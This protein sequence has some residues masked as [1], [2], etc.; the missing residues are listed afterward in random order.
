MKFVSARLINFRNISQAE[1]AFGDQVFLVGPNAQGKT[2]ILEA[3]HYLSLGGSFRSSPEQWLIK[4]GE[5]F[6]RIEGAVELDGGERREVSLVLEQGELGTK[7]TFQIDQN[8]VSRRGFLGNVLTVL[9]A[10]DAIG[11]IRLQ[12]AVRRS[13]INAMMA[14]TSPT[15][16]DD[17][18]NYN[19]A[20]KQ[21][22]QLLSWVRQRRV[23]IAELIPWDDKLSLLG[24]QI[25]QHRQALVDGL[26]RWVGRLFSRLTGD[27]NQKLRLVYKTEAGVVS[28]EQYMARLIKNRDTDIAYGHTTFG[29]H[30]DDLVFL[31]NDQDARHLASQGEFRLLVLALKLAEGEY[32]KE[33]LGETPIYL[34]DDVFSELDNEKVKYVFGLFKDAQVVFTTTDQNLIDQLKPTVLLHVHNGIIKKT[35]EL[36]KN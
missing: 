20:L 33:V 25:I 9:F 17:F 5:S 23:G 24:T 32:I 11:L 28:P 29:P 19:K 13:L 35:Y 14:R 8:K 30:R 36:A 27:P 1:M 12:P 26:N 31:I 22:N 10:P 15:Y 6:A 18:V 7:K 2:N 4:S 34:M 16:W 21:R 3:L